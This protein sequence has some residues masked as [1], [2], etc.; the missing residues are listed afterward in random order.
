MTANP[1]LL[2]FT[3]IEA[4]G[5]DPRTDPILEIAVVLVE[6]GPTLPE[7]ERGSMVIRPPGSHA[8]HDRLW[9]RMIDPVRTMHRESGLWQAA[10]ADTAWNPGDADAAL[11]K[12]IRK[13]TDTLIP[14]AGAGVGHYDLP[15]LR[16]QM[17]RF[18]S[19]LTYW[20]WDVSDIRRGL[21]LAGRHDYVDLDTD[22]KAK[23]HRAAADVDLHL[24]EARRYLAVLQ[25]LPAAPVRA[26]PAT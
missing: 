22:V 20:P 19:L 23:P 7:V 1:P 11:Q 17:P 12:W 24:A 16:Q 4:T 18:H 5:D 25:S 9:A 6:W 13:H 8:D 2:A 3:D 14:I 15:M 21:Q 10:T 26:T